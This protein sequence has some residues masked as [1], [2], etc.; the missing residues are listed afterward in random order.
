MVTKENYVE[1]TPTRL[2]DPRAATAE[3]IIH[4]MEQIISAEGPVM[5]SRVFRIFSRAGGL[6]RI[7]DETKRSF[8]HALR[9]AL[10][11]GIIAAEKE[12]S[13]DP[14]TWILRL[15]PQ[16]SVRVR[17]LGTRTLHE[18][19]ATEL[20]EVMLEIRVENEL[21]SREELFRRVLGEY[22]LNRL[23][24]ATTNRLDFVLKTWF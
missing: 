7:Y 23:T 19:P 24:E 3:Q 1:W 16:K 17:T 13:E 14:T 9:T 12:S 21:I 20:A 2:A 18:V 5:A 4:G 10:D 11:K 15:P 8:L 22:D 6:N